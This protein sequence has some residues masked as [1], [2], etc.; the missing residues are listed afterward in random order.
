VDVVLRMA[1]R[2]RW[3][4]RHLLAIAL[5]AAMILLGRWQWDVAQSQRGGL[6]NLLYSFQWWALGLVIVYGWWR[7]LRD[8]TYG[9]PSAGAAD[10]AAAAPAPALIDDDWAPISASSVELIDRQLADAED[11]DETDDE[12]AAYNKYLEK[13]NARSQRSH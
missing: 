9:R 6:Q 4:P 7:L 13:L 5:T 1:L 12:M 11:A 10:R 2:L 8:D 3:Y